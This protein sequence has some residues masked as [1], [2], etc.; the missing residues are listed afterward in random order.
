MSNQAFRKNV[1][2][3][4]GINEVLEAPVIPS[5]NPLFLA[6]RKVKGNF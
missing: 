1:G 5:I 6:Y 4:I 3:L 2:L